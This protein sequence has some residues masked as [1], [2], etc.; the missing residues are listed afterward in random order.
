MLDF[1]AKLLASR[2]REVDTIHVAGMMSLVAAIG[3]TIYSTIESPMNYSPVAFCTGLATVIG[4]I[5][6]G[7]RLRDGCNPDPAGTPDAH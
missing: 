2:N 7:R 6:G 3:T 5:G 1:L 4:A